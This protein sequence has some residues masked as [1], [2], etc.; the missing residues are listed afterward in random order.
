MKPFRKPPPF[1]TARHQYSQLGVN[2]IVQ[3]FAYKIIKWQERH[4]NDAQRRC[5]GRWVA[6]PTSFDSV[7]LKVLMGH[8][9]GPSAFGCYVLLAELAARM[10]TPGV[11][12]NAELALDAGTMASIFGI[13][14]H[15]LQTAIDLMMLPHIKWIEHVSY[16]DCIQVPTLDN[17]ELLRND[18]VSAT[19]PLR[20]DSVLAHACLQQ[21]QASK[22]AEGGVGGEIH[23]LLRRVRGKSSHVP[24]VANALRSTAQVVTLW[25][26]VTQDETVKAPLGVM[27]AR[28]ADGNV[29]DIPG[30]TCK[31]IVHAIEKQFVHTING[32]DVTNTKL[33]HNK[34]GM[35]INGE[36]AVPV[37][38][39]GEAIYA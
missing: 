19:E 14:D 15:A 9:D 8:A 1:N 16:P 26:D 36:L 4:S 21:Q 11:L 23:A 33:T 5:G 39:L 38:Q 20:T 18:S 37:A 30:L 25:F 28:V 27:A 13:S 6:V 12:A 17:P 34:L 7:G 29:G 31:M 3:D 10:P 24:T 35:Y 2:H 22:Q 32:T